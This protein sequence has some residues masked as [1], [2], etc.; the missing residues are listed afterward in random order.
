[1]ATTWDDVIWGLAERV[2]NGYGDDAEWLTWDRRTM[3]QWR[4]LPPKTRRHWC[5]GVA[6]IARP[7]EIHHE[8]TP[9]LRADA[10]DDNPEDWK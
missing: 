9:L 3:P 1:M 4:E 7:A 2:Y 5:A 10:T 6:K 8:P